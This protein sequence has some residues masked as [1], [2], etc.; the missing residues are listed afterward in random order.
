MN[1]V[2]KLLIIDNQNNYL[3]MHR[4]DHP[5]F[6]VDPDLPGGTLEEGEEPLQTMLREVIEEAGISIDKSAVKLLYSGSEYSEHGTQ[7]YFFATKV[8]E[9]PPIRISWE[10]SSYEWISRDEFLE[11]AKNAKDTY[12]HMV[13]D[14]V[15]DVAI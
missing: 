1:Q 14:A 2:A 7:Y 9:R 15:K 10:H 12:M 3:M 4:S 5:R 13:Y 6:G 8:D 11:K